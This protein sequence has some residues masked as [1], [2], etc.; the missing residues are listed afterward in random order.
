MKL[1]K[2]NKR[3]NNIPIIMPIYW[4]RYGTI[5]VL[6][7]NELLNTLMILSKMSHDCLGFAGVLDG[8]VGI[9]D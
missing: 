2:K 5:S 1:S 3:N 7:I 9:S 4:N 8:L 6:N